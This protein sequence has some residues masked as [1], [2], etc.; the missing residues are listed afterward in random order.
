MDDIRLSNSSCERKYLKKVST[1]LNNYYSYDS[2]NNEKKHGHDASISC[3]LFK[4]IDN[5]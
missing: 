1:H 5:R 3:N 2:S 4:K